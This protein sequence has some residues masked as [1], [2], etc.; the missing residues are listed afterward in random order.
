MSRTTTLI[1][2]LRAADDFPS[3]AVAILE[4][5][6]AI[7]DAALL[8]GDW[9]GARLLRAVVHLRDGGGYVGAWALAAGADRLTPPRGGEELLPS[10]TAWRRVSRTGRAATLDVNLRA[11]TGADGTAETVRWAERRPEP[12]PEAS[13]LRLLAREATHVATLPLHGP[14]GVR[15]LLSVEVRCRAA[16]GTPFVWP[17]CLDAL[18]TAAAIA[19]PW[20][21]ARVEAEPPAPADDPP[22]TDERLPVI[23]PSMRPLVRLAEAFAAED[24][25]L[26]IRG[27]SGTGKSRLARWCHARSSR[28]RAPF[29][30]LDLLGVPQQTQFGELFGWRKGAFTG[31]VRDHD[32]AV[33]RAEGGTLFIDEID[34][35]SL[36]AQAGLLRLLEERVYRPLGDDGRERRADVRFV[37]G[38]NAD[39]G[40]AVAEGRFRADLM[41][42]VDVLPV[43]LPP[44]RDRADEIAD[45][46][47][48]MLRRLAET[49]GQPPRAL[50]EEAAHHLE[51]RPWPGNLRELD[52]VLRR[53]C[54]LAGLEGDATPIEPRHL[55]RAMGLSSATGSPGGATLDDGL[56]ALLLEVEGLDDA[57]EGVDWPGALHGL[58]LARAVRATGDIDRAFTLLGRADV[59]R[60]RNHQR[61]LKR[62]W[63]KALALLDTLGRA[64]DDRAPPG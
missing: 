57:P 44:L 10:A 13:H 53:A 4:H 48:F 9:P 52:N 7:V 24:E 56:D 62:E 2:R 14:Q 40:A 39:L 59:V 12:L 33:A 46:A 37:V 21:L 51:R 35:L 45:W 26:L 15:G 41:Y 28:H 61:T 50:T 19:G 43:S 16:I 34:K 22:P 54:T 55:I 58:L 49:R 64:P 20:L 47:R 63:A 8:V 31:A 27:E 17:A 60:N 36:E 3:T 6:M 25:T 29:V 18:E 11:V 42:R 1:H 30:V 38:T 32:G 23:G 5:L